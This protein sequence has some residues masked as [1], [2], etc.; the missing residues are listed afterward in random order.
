MITLTKKEEKLITSLQQKKFRKQEGLFV[1]EGKKMVQEALSSNFKLKYI[2]STEQSNVQEE[3]ERLCDEKAMHRISSLKTPP[4]ILAVVQQPTAQL[5]ESQII[6]VLDGVKDPGNLGAII[7]TAEALGVKSIILS[8]DTVDLYSPKVIQAT[9]GSIFR[10]NIIYEDLVSLF[11]N[12][13]TSFVYG[14]HLEGNDIYKE[15]IVT[16]CYLVMGSE[17]HGISTEVME[18]VSHPIKIPMVGKAESLNVST[19][20][21]I[22][23]G[24][25]TRQLSNNL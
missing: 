24:E 1:V 16:P 22:I 5:K 18:R 2:V 25:F 17:S 20:T 14:A 4:G 21:A 3:N 6:L 8:L 9:M 11:T 10:I 12:E 15:N 19:A 23:L 13:K 7:R